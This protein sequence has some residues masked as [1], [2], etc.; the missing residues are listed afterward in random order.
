MCLPVP[1]MAVQ[2][3]THPPIRAF[4]HRPNGAYHQLIQAL[5]RR[6][7][8]AGTAIHGAGDTI[9]SA[10][11]LVMSQSALGLLDNDGAWH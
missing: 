9:R 2:T 1:T 7:P 4:T 11:H 6:N 5:Q 8:A 10:A 3:P